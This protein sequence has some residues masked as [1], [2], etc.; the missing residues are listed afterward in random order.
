VLRV[1]QSPEERSDDDHHHH[2]RRRRH[3]HYHRKVNHDDDNDDND[4]MPIR[5]R[6][7]APVSHLLVILLLLLP[8]P[9]F[10]PFISGFLDRLT[11]ACIKL[12]SKD[13]AG[14]LVTMI[15]AARA[16]LCD[17]QEHEQ[18]QQ[19]QQQR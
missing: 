1:R 19:Q 3:H 6:A 18:Q 14:H 12:R 17:R 7:R 15:F 2:R 4:S 16:A 5:S 8:L 13:T 11:E 10:R 9:P